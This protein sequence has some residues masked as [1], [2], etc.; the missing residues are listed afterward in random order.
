MMQNDYISRQ[1]E[2]IGRTLAA[3]L[4]GKKAG[5]GMINE[6]LES[7]DDLGINPDAI[8]LHMLIK[9]ITEGKINEAENLLFEYIK[10]GT[11]E[12]RLQIAEA[13][14]AELDDLSDTFLQENNFSRQEIIEGRVESERLYFL[15]NS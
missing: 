12:N 11:G 14:Y 4:V 1:I 2:A 15:Q 10:E 3:V 8:L 7:D 9:H 13:F 5:Y 6:D